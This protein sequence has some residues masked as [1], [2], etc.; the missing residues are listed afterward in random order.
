MNDSC[1]LYHEGVFGEEVSTWHSGGPSWCAWV[2]CRG[3]ST[4]PAADSPNYEDS[5]ESQGKRKIWEITGTQHQ[6]MSSS[7]A[8]RDHVLKTE[9]YPE[10]SGKQPSE[11]Q[12]PASTVEGPHAAKIIYGYIFYRRKQTL[13]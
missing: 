10:D 6:V 11:I 8:R 3:P 13:T 5:E 7:M 9:N 1:V 2:R 12:D 4:K